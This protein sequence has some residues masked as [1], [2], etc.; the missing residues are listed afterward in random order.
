MHLV[1]KQIHAKHYTDA[2][3]WAPAKVCN[4][5]LC[6]RPCQPQQGQPQHTNT[7][8]RTLAQIP[9]CGRLCVFM[10]VWMCVCFG[11]LS[12]ALGWAPFCLSS[13]RDSRLS[14]AASC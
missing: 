8:S 6:V 10:G 1:Q 14:I 3:P 5:F 12:F 7:P 9:F 11:A 4:T 2:Q 13:Q